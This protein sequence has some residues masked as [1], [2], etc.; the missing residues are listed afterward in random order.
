MQRWP[1]FFVIGAMKAGTTTLHDYL[2]SHQDIFMVQPKEPGFFSQPEVWARGE[3]W[4]L[5]LY[6]SAGDKKLWGDGSTCYS[7]WPTYPHV[8]ERIYQR[9]PNAKFIYL[10][11]EPVA[12]A[13]SHYRHRMEEVAVHGG[14]FMTFSE[15][16]DRDE[17]ML[18]AGCYAI[19]LEKFYEFFNVDQCFIVDFERLTSNS[20]QVL[21]EICAFLDLDPARFVHEAPKLSN[22]AGGV[23]SNHRITTRLKA[24][25]R[26][27][28]AREILDAVSPEMRQKLLKSLSS[29]A[30]KSPIGKRISQNYVSSISPA[31]EADIEKL[32]QYYHGHNLALEAL[33]GIRFSPVKNS[34]KVPSTAAAS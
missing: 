25:R 24:I 34:F 28:V 17:E 19:Q 32:V 3:D 1:D 16:I 6:E 29:L 8:P 10:V 21:G 13:Y 12:R 22:A 26:L 11:R 5:K 27:P 33:T 7:R 20:D 23:V 14:E 18:M 9:N 4:Y 30:L 15:A 31:S 2:V